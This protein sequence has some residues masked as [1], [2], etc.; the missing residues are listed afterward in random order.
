MEC[1]PPRIMVM[2]IA[3]PLIKKDEHANYVEGKEDK[4]FFLLTATRGKK[5]RQKNG[6]LIQAYECGIT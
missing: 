2:N 4:E 1:A 5:K 3:T 6:I